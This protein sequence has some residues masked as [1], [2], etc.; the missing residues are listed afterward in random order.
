MSDRP[1]PFKGDIL[2]VDDTPDNLRLLASMLSE[3]GYKVRKAI[4]GQL[5]LMAAQS[6][7]PDLILLDI[8]MPDMDGYEVC[9]RLKRD[10]QT[11]D[12]PVIFISALD[13]VLD[14]VKAFS[15]GGVDYVTK[16]FQLQEVL[17]RM[18]NQ[19]VVRRLQKHLQ[20]QN[21][22]LKQLL[23]D[24]IRAQESLRQAEEKY[25]AIF[26]NAIEGIFQTSAEGEYLNANQ[27]LAN[28]Y[29]YGSADELIDDFNSNDV[30]PYVSMS[31]RKE[32]ENTLQEFGFVS[33]FESQIYRRD[34]ST[35]WIRESINA[36]RDQQ[37]EVIF[38][39]GTVEDISDRRSA[40]IA[41]SAR[42]NMDQLQ[43]IAQAI[44]LPVLISRTADGEILYANPIA[45]STFGIASWDLIGR[46]IQ[47][48]YND[49]QDAYNIAEVLERDGYVRNY[50][51][52]CKPEGR[53]LFKVLLS[54][55]PFIFDHKPALLSIFFH[56]S[57][58]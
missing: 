1:E 21:L 43:T 6:A 13:D 44:P 12:I 35:A 57:D 56:I 8:N 25:R 38:Y 33:G 28:I 14:K 32:F 54:I 15:V 26:D 2:V 34:G 37:D 19:L 53:N 7:P 40:E 17:A 50:K 42:Q 39:V 48:L 22:Q 16:P 52:I 31:L 46:S 4:N 9:E 5:A 27:A 3:Q 45:S 47:S 10:V 20:D 29:G 36:V 41:E 24:R 49:L 23:R 55:Q 58:R 11:L 18:D 51:L 30:K